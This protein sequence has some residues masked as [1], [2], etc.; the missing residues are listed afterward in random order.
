[1]SNIE[2][3]RARAAELGIDVDGRWSEARLEAAIELE[4]K[5]LSGDK[6]E[7]GGES[8]VSGENSTQLGE[9]LPESNNE[10]QLLLNEALSENEALENTIANLNESLR[11]ANEKIAELSDSEKKLQEENS[12]FKD[13]LI[14]QS[15]EIN[16][17]LVS[18]IGYAKTFKV[19]NKS[20]GRIA[21]LDLLPGA[22]R[23]ITEAELLDARLLKRI[24][25]GIKIGTL[26]K[27]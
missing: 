1:M 20:N 9:N 7:A 21:S 5:K 4:E 14:K 13:S 6:G 8:Q 18:T 3:L 24:E 22:Q 12:K 17:D 19:K 26:E 2:K 23:E 10:T 16:S 25:H 11:L 15:A 27:V